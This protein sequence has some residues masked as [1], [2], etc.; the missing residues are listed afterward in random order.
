MPEPFGTHHSKMLVLFSV[1]D[2]GNHEMARVVVHTANMIPFDWE[3]MTQGVWDSGWLPLLLPSKIESP[4]G[5]E[6]KHSLLRYLNAYTFSRTGELI[7]ELP[8]YDFSSIRAA[9]LGSVPGKFK[10]SDCH[11]GWPGLKHILRS[12]HIPAASMIKSSTVVAQISSIATLA[13]GAKDTWLSPFFL[14]ALAT[15]APTKHPL[16]KPEFAIVFPTPDEVRKSLNGY[17]SGG[18]IHLKAVTPIQL[19]QIDYLR[20]Y[21][22]RWA[23]SLAP[24]PSRSSK[25]KPATDQIQPLRLSARAI[26]APHIKTYIRFT[27]SSYT[28][29]SWALLTSANLSTQAWGSAPSGCSTNKKRNKQSGSL[30]I[31]GPENEDA[32]EREVKISSY[33]AGVIVYPELFHE[34]GD[35]EVTLK[36][37]FDKDELVLEQELGDV[38]QQEVQEE[39]NQSHGVQQGEGKQILVGIRMPYDLPLVRY[40][41][42]EMP[43]SP[44]RSYAERDCLGERWIV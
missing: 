14:D 41:P 12:V 38:K 28:H 5:A 19:K 15:S 31:T 29:I 18:S 25:P 32:D 34:D 9:F 24:S 17:D 36:P 22:C 13:P 21:F 42:G 39:G 37:L 35:N 3:N 40:A 30:V 20:P 6:F 8:K 27:D 4:I 11:F 7:T 33:E 43:W 44:G 1:G 10:L 2:D 16:K 23:A 26:A